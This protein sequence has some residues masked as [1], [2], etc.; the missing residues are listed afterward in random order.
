MDRK[1]CVGDLYDSGCDGNSHLYWKIVSV[2]PFQAHWVFR[3]TLGFHQESAYG[4]DAFIRS[5]DTTYVGNFDKSSKF[6]EIYD[7]LNG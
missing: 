3:D 4:F 6:K 2:N 5:S 7:I 1:P